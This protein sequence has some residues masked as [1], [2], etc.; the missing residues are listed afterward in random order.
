MAIER[1][2]RK[3]A[4]PPYFEGLAEWQEKLSRV[5]IEE[6]IDFSEVTLE[7]LSRGLRLKKSPDPN[8]PDSL[9]QDEDRMSKVKNGLINIIDSANAIFVTQ[10]YLPRRLRLGKG[11]RE[12]DSLPDHAARAAHFAIYYL[13]VTD[14]AIIATLVLHDMPNLLRDNVGGVKKDELIRVLNVNLL[15]EQHSSMSRGTVA[16]IVSMVL[17]LDEED[18]NFRDISA[19]VVHDP[20]I[21]AKFPLGSEHTAESFWGLYEM[22]TKRFTS[23]ESQN[24]GEYPDLLKLYTKVMKTPNQAVTAIREYRKYVARLAL[25]YEK[26][27]NPKAGTTDLEA[28]SDGL[29]VLTQLWP[30]ARGLDEGIFSRYVGECVARAFMPSQYRELESA[31]GEMYPGDKLTR[32]IMFYEKWYQQLLED[33]IPEAVILKPFE[34]IRREYRL[35][36][37]QKNSD[38]LYDVS[39]PGGDSFGLG[40]IVTKSRSSLYWKML[41][42]WNNPTKKARLPIHVQQMTFGSKDFWHYSLSHHHDIFRTQLLLFGAGYKGNR[43]NEILKHLEQLA[44]SDENK[45]EIM[46]DPSIVERSSE[47]WE[48]KM[49]DGGRYANILFRPVGISTNLELQQKG[50]RGY[51]KSSTE[52]DV[53]HHSAYKN[54]NQSGWRGYEEKDILQMVAGARALRRAHLATIYGEVLQEQERFSQKGSVYQKK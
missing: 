48:P 33:I 49:A 42:I 46:W 40:P 20:E 8:I 24:R 27:A 43:R 54:R 39:L 22:V 18:R 4:P 25:A 26:Y 53:F 41:E 6:K 45:A 36:T 23:G 17:E 21:Q 19:R 52:I 30:I 28:Q 5:G 51:A 11:H 1:L 2:I 10:G 9:W 47:I 12:K 32:E 16:E 13:G 7:S 44:L 15:E 35:L 29:M 37:G 3:E 50:Q 31:V 34:M 38:G 14:P